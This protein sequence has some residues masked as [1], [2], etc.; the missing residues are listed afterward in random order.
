M[1][2]SDKQRFHEAR[3]LVE[4]LLALPYMVLLQNYGAS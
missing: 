1:F 4:E 2:L 3:G